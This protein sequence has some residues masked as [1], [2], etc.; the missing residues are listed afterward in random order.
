MDRVF[1]IRRYI[2]SLESSKQSD[3]QLLHDFI[4]SCL[5]G[6]KLWF[7][8]G[9]NVANKVV[10]NPSI[11]YGSYQHQFAIGRCKELFQIGLSANTKG[12]SIHLMG[13]RHALDIAK[14]FGHQI[15]KAKVSSYCIQ[16]KHIKDI[17]L[18]VLKQAILLAVK[19]SAHPQ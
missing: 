4:M 12:I 9:I 5:P 7:N 17:H 11:G 8:T 2:N 1:E 16:F 10:S 14:T 13:I 18:E 19:T 15:G 3:M 6:T